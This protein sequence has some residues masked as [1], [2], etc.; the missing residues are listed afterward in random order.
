ML[1]M[2]KGAVALNKTSGELATV[3]RDDRA[4][5][6]NPPQKHLSNRAQ[7]KPFRGEISGK[8]GDFVADYVKSITC[9]QG[10]P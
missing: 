4:T 9:R 3:H 8:H 5:E 10:Q 6:N 1:R 2:A 7:A